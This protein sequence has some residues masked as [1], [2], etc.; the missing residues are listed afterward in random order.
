MAGA[1]S[2][3]RGRDYDVMDMC[4]VNFSEVTMCHQAKIY[5]NFINE[6]EKNKKRTDNLPYSHMDLIHDHWTV[7]F[8]VGSFETRSSDILYEYETCEIEN[9]KWMTLI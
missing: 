6:K 7:Y 5:E 8:Q 2:V 9:G 3:A 4:N 1:T